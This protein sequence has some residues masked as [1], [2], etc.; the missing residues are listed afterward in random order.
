MHSALLSSFL[1]TLFIK[2]IR[3]FSISGPVAF[4]YVTGLM[5][6]NCFNLSLN[7]LTG[8]LCLIS[9]LWV[10]LV[11]LISFPS[12]YLLISL[13]TDAAGNIS[14]FGFCFPRQ[15]P[16]I[17]EWFDLEGTILFQ[18]QPWAGTPSTIPDCLGPCPAWLGTLP[19]MDII[20]LYLLWQVH[21]FSN[22]P[23]SLLLLFH[24]A[25]IFLNHGWEELHTISRLG[26]DN[27]LHVALTY[28]NAEI[29]SAHI[30]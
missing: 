10:I 28:L 22:H 23:Y 16:R 18:P 9:A 14:Y 5:L 4:W 6:N 13:H 25:S 2:V 19:G 11:L 8:S 27:T 3:L 15:D 12:H 20:Y 29:T 1:L 26:H 17:P 21:N 7:L 24:L 30:F